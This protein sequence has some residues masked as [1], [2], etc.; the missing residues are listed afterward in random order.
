[1]SATRMWPTLSQQTSRR[2]IL[3]MS[4]VDILPSYT[5]WMSKSWLIYNKFPSNVRCADVIVYVF[6][7]TSR[8]SKIN[9]C[10]LLKQITK[11]IKPNDLAPCLV[12]FLQTD[13]NVITLCAADTTWFYLFLL[14]S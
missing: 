1:M 14:F 3:T 7:Y 8:T 6:T 13:D 12:N 2:V 11:R 5:K 10:E 9:M 4:P